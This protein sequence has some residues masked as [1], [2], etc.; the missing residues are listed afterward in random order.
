LRTNWVI[1][2]L[3]LAVFMLIQPVYGA[4]TITSYSNDASGN[5]YPVADLNGN[6][7]FTV[8]TNET[9]TL[10]QWYTDGVNQTNNFD[11][12]TESWATK[13]YKTVAVNCTN[14]NGTTETITWNPYV[15][16]E[17]ASGPDEVST[18]SESGYDTLMDE[19]AVENP[20]FETILYSTTEPYTDIIGNVFF[21]ILWGLPM[22]MLWIK[23]ESMLMPC[24]F[25]LIMGTL[26]LAF[27]PSS[28]ATTASAMIVLS[29]M[30][31]I[32]MWAKA[33]R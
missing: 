15:K 2:V 28:F 5:L 4:P 27:L 16:Q 7:V 19:I 23:Q 9:I 20:D 17:M 6:I 18:M 13:G 12:L 14:A 33:K 1:P 8:V 21:L 25:G 29:L 11:N 24:M 31:I 22:V 3:C 26:L 30:G 32:Y 10:Y